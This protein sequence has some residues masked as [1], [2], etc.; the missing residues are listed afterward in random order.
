MQCPRCDRKLSKEDRFCSRCGLARSTDGK[1]VDPLIGL[2]VSDRYRIEERIGVGGMGTVYRAQHIRFGQDVAIKVLHERY[3]GD[4][5]LARR[6][7][8][9]ALTYGQ[10]SHPNLVGLHDFGRTPDGMFFMA[11][12]YCPGKPLSTLLR[13]RGHF[14]WRLATD[15]VMQVA[16]G[17]GAAHDCSVVHRDLKPENIILTEI[18]PNRYHVRLLDFGIA[19]R[20]DEDGPRL[21]QAGMVFGT[22]E[23]MSPEQARGKTVD[24]RSDLYALGTLF[25]EL[26][27]GHPPFHGADKLRV[28]QQQ[29]N[30]SPT[31]PSDY[32]V[33]D[34]SP[35]IEKI[36]MEC[37][38]KD[39]AARI[40]TA[41]DFL[42]RI[43]DSDPIFSH[44]VS[45]SDGSQFDESP[46]PSA[47][48]SEMEPTAEGVEWSSDMVPEIES[49]TQTHSPLMEGF[50][51]HRSLLTNRTQLPILGA[52][53]TIVAVVIG[54][55][56]LVR[57][58][59]QS[60]TAPKI[61]ATVAQTSVDKTVSEVQRDAQRTAEV[62]P[63]LGVNQ[64][65]AAMIEKPIVQSAK[66][67]QVQEAAPTPLKEKT[68]A[69]TSVLSESP[70]LRSLKA[71]E[72]GLEQRDVLATEKA[73][74]KA[75]KQGILNR[76]PTQIRRYR[77]AHEGYKSLV[78][79]R[80][81]SKRKYLKS[82]KTH[83]KSADFRVALK[84][85]E[86]AKSNGATEKEVKRL[87]TKI[88]DAKKALAKARKYYA[89]ADCR[90]TLRSL[91][92][93]MDVTPKSKR[94]AKLVNACTQALPP[95]RL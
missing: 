21:T 74:E 29:A 70:V 42:Q 22:P 44:D 18:R 90:K 52:I 75:K 26:I 36:I 34:L 1:P 39:P 87:R 41:D 47:F 77:R 12:E 88:A 51:H 66:V 38:E 37:L 94:V 72:R 65:S 64:K 31:P 23:Y 4:E 89:K 35:A 71:A 49:D 95:Q 14:N 78:K 24:K 55:G 61:E 73:L 83:L 6:F 79:A 92:P 17:L 53:M 15:I 16:Q 59:S 45:L 40:A 7:E 80:E 3:T 30:E 67:E 81:Q 60:D 19:K 58:Q 85:L 86:S 63:T 46:K 27:V 8:K 32:D 33:G 13:Q 93:I 84:D 50:H 20:E 56:L 25:Y 57:G 62:E 76:D 48:T 91:Q 54:G 68:K 28:M 10:V 2:T 43:E 69:P 11:L 5:K 9:E 82:A